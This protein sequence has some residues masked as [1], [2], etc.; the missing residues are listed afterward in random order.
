MGGHSLLFIYITVALSQG[1]IDQWEL[2]DETIHSE[3]QQLALV[4]PLY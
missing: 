3:L 4:K 2:A 1:S